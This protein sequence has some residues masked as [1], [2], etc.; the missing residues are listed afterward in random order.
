M[1]DFVNPK[2]RK[3]RKRLEW[4][5]NHHRILL[6]IH[7]LPRDKFKMNDLTS[8]TKLSRQTVGKH[9]DRMMPKCIKRSKKKGWY[10]INRWH[11]NLMFCGYHGVPNLGFVVEEIKQAMNLDKPFIWCGNSKESYIST[12]W[13]CPVKILRKWTHDKSHVDLL[14]AI[15]Q[16]IHTNVQRAGLRLKDLDRPIICIAIINPEALKKKPVEKYEL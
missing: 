11:F 12:H 8:R 5:K 13:F 14:N 1:S 6:A 3:R 4:N 9:L 2:S 10:E 7:G 16:I 15:S